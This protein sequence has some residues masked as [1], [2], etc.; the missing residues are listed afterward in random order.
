MPDPVLV[1]V[2]CLEVVAL[3]FFFSNGFRD[4]ANSISCIVSTRVLSPTHALYRAAFS[5]FAATLVIG[6]SSSRPIE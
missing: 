2:V 4:A 1:S 5:H 6:T 3:I